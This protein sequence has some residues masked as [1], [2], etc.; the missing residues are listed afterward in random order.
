MRTALAASAVAAA[1]AG[2][3]D[4]GASSARSS[5]L[6]AQYEHMHSSLSTMA[7]SLERS[8]EL[9]AIHNDGLSDQER[10]VRVVKKL[11]AHGANVVRGI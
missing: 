4:T 11:L 7:S 6:L 1:T 9:A 8:L 2:D 10:Q 5:G 3:D